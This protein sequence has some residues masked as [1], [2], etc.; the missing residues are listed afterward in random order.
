[1]RIKQDHVRRVE[2]SRYWDELRQDIGFGLRQLTRKP[3]LPALIVL[4]LAL[5]IGV[6]SYVQHRRQQYAYS[7]QRLQAMI[8][9]VRQ[10][11]AN[12]ARLIITSREVMETDR[13]RSADVN[14][15]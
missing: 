11:N 4:L 5:G 10:D 6:N 8:Q 2:T 1:M 15:A 12:V 13:Q 7:E 14:R 3:A 9:D